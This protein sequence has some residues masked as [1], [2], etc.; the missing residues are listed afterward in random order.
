[1]FETHVATP[2]ISRS[3]S[4]RRASA[5]TGV[6]ASI[7]ATISDDSRTEQVKVLDEIASHRSKAVYDLIITATNKRLQH[8]VQTI[9]TAIDNLT[10][11]GKSCGT[12]PRRSSAGFANERFFAVLYAADDK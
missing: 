10:G 6:R 8:L 9:S 11:I 7:T 2:I 5:G 1:M 12:I 3:R 4:A